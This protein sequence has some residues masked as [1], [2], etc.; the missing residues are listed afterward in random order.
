LILYFTRHGES[1][2]N[3]R[4][5]FS[6]RDLPHHLTDT[7]IE[8][9]RQLARLLHGYGIDEIWS[10]PVPR[11]IDT[12]ELVSTSLGLNY[13][14]TSGLREFD[15]GRFEGTSAEDGWVEYS[16]VL[17]S[18]LDGDLERR[19]G[20]GESLSELVARLRGFLQQFLSKAD[21]DSRVVL[22]GH[23]GL[24]RMALPHIFANVSP[25]FAY[26][27]TPGY[28]QLIVA[29]VKDREFICIEWAGITG[30]RIS[31]P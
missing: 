20:G 26:A 22:V 9:A 19:V 27:N 17:R 8:H 14:V 21:S 29:D 4:R 10:S 24:Y 23:G 25:Q 15:V 31:K 3:L 6:N 30:D 18:W 2:A 16:S 13:R 28:G 7:G 5:T 1:E 12:A 11:A